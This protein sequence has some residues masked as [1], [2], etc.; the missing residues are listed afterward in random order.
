VQPSRLADDGRNAAIVIGLDCITGLQTARILARRGVPVIGIAAD[1]KHPCART[2][3]C[4]KI[5]AGPTAN[6]G[7]IATLEEL[8]PTLE[9]RAVLYP[10]TDA[11][12]LVVGR[13][14]VRLES[15]FHVAL[16]DTPMLE[17]LADKVH[18]AHYAKRAGLPIPQTALLHNRADAVRAAAE[19]NFPCILKPASRSEGW[20]KNI[21]SKVFRAATPQE[22]IELYDR[23]SPWS[24]SFVAQQWI[25]GSDSDL[26]SCNCYF[27]ATGEPI[28][29]FVARKLRQ[30]PPR[31]GVSC[32]G[33]ECRNDVVHDL[34]VR[35]FRSVKFHG[36]GYLEV[37]RDSRTGEHYV[38]EANVGRPT[39]RSA[40]AEAGGVDLLYTMYCDTLGL[41]LPSGLVQW[42]TGV[43]W[44]YWRQDLRSAFY[45][46]RTGELSLVE[47]ARS[48][49][50]RKVDAVFSW[51]D[52]R[53]FLADISKVARR[54]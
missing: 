32:L 19:L 34:T 20:E 31:A 6:S 51:S 4:E 16:P 3:V 15:W 44:I 24:D 14:R 25:E 8:G 1:P 42:H 26:Y 43:K 28:V 5:V 30:W 41:P 47:W 40:I 53:P 37:K 38:I 46:W 18:F 27:D 7:L 11:A 10:C 9:R 48:W 13:N 54:L 35:L 36:L 49:R 33:E 22:L 17:S 45:Y 21:G 50:G 23:C 29:T 52:P 39:G 12:V 2:R